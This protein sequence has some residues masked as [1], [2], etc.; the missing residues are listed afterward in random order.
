MYLN[1]NKQQIKITSIVYTG[2]S[3]SIPATQLNHIKGQ[4]KPINYSNWFRSQR[5]PFNKLNH[6]Q[7]NSITKPIET[8]PNM[9]YTHTK[10]L[11]TWSRPGGSRYLCCHRQ[12]HLQWARES[13]APTRIHFCPKRDGWIS[14]SFETHQPREDHGRR[15]GNQAWRSR[16]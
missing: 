1:H 12:A 2:Q 5:H 14:L 10:N 16:G 6:W 8:N 11:H 15:I 13:N 9:N 7:F 3:P 4:I